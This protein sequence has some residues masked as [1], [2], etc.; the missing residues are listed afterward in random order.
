MEQ[1]SKSLLSAA[2]AV[3]WDVDMLLELVV[4]MAETL[5]LLA[6]YGNLLVQAACST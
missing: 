3:L 2:G 4:F 1:V 5:S 6:S